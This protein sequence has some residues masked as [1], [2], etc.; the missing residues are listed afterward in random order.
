MITGNGSWGVFDIFFGLFDL[1]NANV[2]VIYHSYVGNGH[3]LDQVFVIIE[4]AGVFQC[5]AAGNDGSDLAG[6]YIFP[7]SHPY[8]L[9]VGATDSLDVW[10][11]STNGYNSADSI[12][13]MIYAPGEDI[14]TL[15]VGDDTTRVEGTSFSAP[16]IAGVAALMMDQDTW[17]EPA[18]IREYLIESADEIMSGTKKRV[19]AETAVYFASAKRLASE[20]GLALP[21]HHELLDNYPNPFNGSTVIRFVVQERSKNVNLRIHNVAGQHVRTY[22]LGRLDPGSHQL[23]WD[24]RAES[25]LSLAAGVYTY[26]LRLDG[27]AAFSRKLLMLK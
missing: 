7:A 2:E 27:E 25:G 11:D 8:V 9:M 18:D 16:I 4:N 23:S 15:D 26:Q 10:T 5:A 17:L 13:A 22:N 3:L 6:V 12:D 19:D 21:E 14:L 1:L 20:S 24:G